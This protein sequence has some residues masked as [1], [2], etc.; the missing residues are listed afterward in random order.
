[1]TLEPNYFIDISESGSVL[2]SFLKTC[3]DVEAYNNLKDI[4]IRELNELFDSVSLNSSTYR[5]IQKI[6]KRT[7][8]RFEK[9]NNLTCDYNDGLPHIALESVAQQIIVPGL[10]F[11]YISGW[12]GW[13]GRKYVQYTNSIPDPNDHVFAEIII[14]VPKALRIMFEGYKW[15]FDLAIELKTNKF[16]VSNEE[17]RQSPR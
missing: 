1:M 9:Y 12:I 10:V 7:E 4:N 15:P 6:I 8:L 13:V 16:F 17:I 2:S 5:K 11:I 14:D 3:K